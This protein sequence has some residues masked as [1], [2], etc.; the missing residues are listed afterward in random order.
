MNG[1][2]IGK[3]AGLGLAILAL[4]GIV[5]FE[6]M[7]D[8]PS[9]D[10]LP[11]PVAPGRTRQA[12]GSVEPAYQTDRLL[13]E[14]LAR[15]V[16]SPDRR[17]VASAARTT[18]GLPRLTGIVVAGSQ[19]IAIFAASPGGRPIAAAKGERVGAYEVREISSDGV[20]MSGPDGTTVITPIFDSAP[21]PVRQ[22]VPARVEKPKAPTK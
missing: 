7:A 3:L 2:G 21:P 4:S 12:A 9:P 11:N 22:A 13:R 18:S 1:A 16:F 15:P 10:R 5:A 19:Q 20:T 8:Q 17:P 14:I 6:I